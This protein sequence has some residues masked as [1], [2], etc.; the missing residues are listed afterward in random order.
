MEDSL[1]LVHTVRRAAPERFRL[2]F[3]IAEKEA[4]AAW[5]R[6]ARIADEAVRACRGR[7]EQVG[8]DLTCRELP[9]AHELTHRDQL[10]HVHQHSFE[11]GVPLEQRD[12]EMP[13]TA[14]TARRSSRT[15]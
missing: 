13:E 7:L 8:I 9:I 4:A 12:D 1:S 6:N 10:R 15:G 2:V 5:R 11:G 3:V 14:A